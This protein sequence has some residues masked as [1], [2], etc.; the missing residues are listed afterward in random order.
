MKALF[1]FL[2]INL[3]ICAQSTLAPPKVGFV[4]DGR[5]SVH[6]V[7]GLAGNF[8]TGPTV[9][10]GAVAAAYSGSLGL[11]KT[12]A[13]LIVTDANGQ[14]I[15]NT[16]AP[17]GRALFGFAAGGHAALAYFEA[18]GAL[19]IWNGRAFQSVPLDAATLAGS[20]VVSIAFEDSNLAAFV[21]ERQDALWKVDVRTDTGA[22]VSQT[23]LPGVTAPALLVASGDLVYANTRGLVVRKADG[24]EKQVAAH[25]PKNFALEQMGDGWVEVRDLASGRLYALCVQSGHEAYYTLP[26]VRQ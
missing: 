3:V 2:S 24:V 18:T 17:G 11:I 1:T 23:A 16:N 8:L 15:A 9:S 13:Q 20:M 4:Q 10:T 14:A 25:L 7:V 5:S 21:V 6:A 26:E 12:D 19:V 22:V